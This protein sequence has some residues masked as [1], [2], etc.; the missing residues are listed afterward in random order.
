MQI[1]IQTLKEKLDKGLGE[2]DILLDVRS[3]EEFSAGHIPGAVNLPLD[4]IA[5]RIDDFRHYHKIYIN[6]HSGGRSSAACEA[7]EKLALPGTVNIIGG[8]GA[9][10]EAGH[11]VEKLEI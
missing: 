3:S 1:D 7:F 8:F 4:E 6:C 9:W 2:N 5:S 10:Q 11:P